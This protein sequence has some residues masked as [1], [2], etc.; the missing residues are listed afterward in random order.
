MWNEDQ[1][2]IAIETCFA[3]DSFM[4]EMNISHYESLFN[5][6][7][8]FDEPIFKKISTK[9]A[10]LKLVD[11]SL[12]EQLENEYPTIM[13]ISV[14]DPTHRWG[15]YRKALRMDI[16]EENMHDIDEE[17][18]FSKA[19]HRINISI[20]LSKLEIFEDILLHYL[21]N[22]EINEENKKFIQIKKFLVM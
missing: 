13:H 9:T 20:L 19:E 7:E 22:D 18:Y 4:E 5:I 8:D 14:M 10:L 17:K 6:I 16:P 15:L 12:L 3:S 21:K 11:Y 2:K 1:I